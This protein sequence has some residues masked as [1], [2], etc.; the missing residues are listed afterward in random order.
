MGQLQD[1]SRAT[2]VIVIMLAMALAIPFPF[3][4][5]AQTPPPPLGDWI[6]EDDTV[7]Q[8][9]NIS[10]WGDI[11]VASGGNLTLIDC[12][13]EFNCLVPSQYG[14]LVEEGGRISFHN[15][16]LG[17]VNENSGFTFEIQGAGLLDGCHV[18]GM[19]DRGIDIYGDDVLVTNC[20]IHDNGWVGYGITLHDSSP[21]I[22][23]NSFTDNYGGIIIHGTSGGEIY[24]NT[25]NGSEWGI[26]YF[27]ESTTYSYNNTLK[28]NNYGFIIYDLS[29]PVV[30]GNTIISNN[31]GVQV[32]HNSLSTVNSNYFE[33]NG[34]AFQAMESSICTLESNTIKRSLQDGVLTYD[35]CHVG[36]MNN[37]ITGSLEDG[38]QSQDSSTISASGNII[39]GNAGYGILLLH[40]SSAD[41]HDN[42]LSSNEYGIGCFNTTE[43]YATGNTISGNERG[44]HSQAIPGSYLLFEDNLLEGNDLGVVALLNADITI[45]DSQIMN[46]TERGITA[47]FGS[48]VK[49]D[50]CHVGS[51]GEEGIYVRDTSSPLITDTS[52]EGSDLHDI[53][54]GNSSAPTFISCDFN[55]Q[56]IFHNDSESELLLGW[57]VDFDVKDKDDTSVDGASVTITDS[58][59][60][61]AYQGTTNAN[62]QILDIPLVV[63]KIKKG[64][65]TELTPHDFTA[66]KGELTG[67]TVSTITEDSNV[68]IKFSETYI[69]DDPAEPDGPDEP[70]GE[71]DE[72]TSTLN[73][74]GLNIMTASLL[75]VVVLIVIVIV[76]VK[77]KNQ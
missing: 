8:E 13:V 26:A 52:I 19:F 64:G 9:E 71:E 40:E 2:V 11:I 49:I 37:T 67:R 76:G 18:G 65:T 50:G 28:S 57:W 63:K 59:G 46:S 1:F 58:T 41:V 5:A 61:V 25:I 56:S 16:T 39:Q 32:K 15:T 12:I 27:E 43:I 30:T 55:A 22:S 33:G 44:I 14:I 29:K 54:V 21:T 70:G 31:Y 47:A 10:V 77:K 17:S 4:A 66:K 24:G 48:E 38:I 53:W 42:T 3:Q 7:I 75:I 51:T 72:S 6:I 69:P 73:F 20:W 60:T 23:Y 74:G 62:G 68:L 35:G 45:K 36:V 34:Y